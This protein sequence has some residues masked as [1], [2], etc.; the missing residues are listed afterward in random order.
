[1]ESDNRRLSDSRIFTEIT[2]R[3]PES[4]DSM[5]CDIK[6]RRALDR[7]SGLIALM[8]EVSHFWYLNVDWSGT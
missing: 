8:F 6:E 5:T 2:L 7:R 1:M 3:Y 4:Q